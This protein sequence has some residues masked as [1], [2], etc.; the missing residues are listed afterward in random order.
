[1]LQQDSKSIGWYL[2][3]S[4]VEIMPVLQFV[5]LLSVLPVLK[6]LNNELYQTDKQRLV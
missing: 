3:V 1:M 5:R 4:A 2:N 6:K